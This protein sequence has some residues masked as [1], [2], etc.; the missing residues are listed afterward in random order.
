M[1]GIIYMG[2]LIEKSIWT[3]M[4]ATSIQQDE[5]EPHHH[6][7]VSDLTSAIIF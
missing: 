5:T 1:S 6:M 2:N 3:R 7:N 4:E